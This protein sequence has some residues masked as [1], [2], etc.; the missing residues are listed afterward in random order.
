MAVNK[1]QILL[2]AYF[3][4]VKLNNEAFNTYISIIIMII[5]A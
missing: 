4:N 3:R 5:L 1:K 2:G